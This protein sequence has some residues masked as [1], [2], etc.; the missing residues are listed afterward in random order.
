MP[1]VSIDHY[2]LEW[3]PATRLRGLPLAASALV[4]LLGT[5]PT[6]GVDVRRAE[7]PAVIDAS[8]ILIRQYIVGLVDETGIPVLTAQVWVLLQPLHQGAVTRTDDLDRRIGLYME[9]AVVIAF[10][11]QAGVFTNSLGFYTRC[12]QVTRH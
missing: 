3:A 7:E 12:Q 9:D 10:V 2:R 5:L 6:Q 11:I 8:S 4:A 1:P